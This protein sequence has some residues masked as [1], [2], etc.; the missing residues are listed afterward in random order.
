MVS[1]KR[2]LN[3]SDTDTPLRQVVS[4]LLEKI[5]SEAVVAD[6]NEVAAFR[7]DIRSLRDHVDQRSTPE[8]IV[9]TA[10]SAAVIMEAYNNEISAFLRKQRREL[11]NI[12][13][14]MMETVAA[15]TGEN[16][17]AVE[18]L[19]GIG[20]NLERTL[21]AADLDTLKLNLAECLQDFRQE[22]LRQKEE[23]E[24]M[25][26][27]LRRDIERGPQQSVPPEL[28]EIDE[29]TSLP[30]KDACVKAMHA[31][32]PPGKRRYVV[33]LVL[34]RLQAVNARFGFEVGNRVLCRFG[35]FIEQQILPEDR[36]FR[37]RGPALVA[38]LER[39]EGIDMIRAQIRRMLE[40]RLEQTLDVE[41][42]PVMI[43]VSARWSA[44]QL[45]TT[46]AAAEKQIETFAASQ[47]SREYI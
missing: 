6:E 20:D 8:E 42:R 23:A 21:A 46:V 47:M 7:T 44:F 45:T 35:E 43:T 15:I 12:V 19:R 13:T 22:T 38:V 30:L 28:T 37:W 32:I 1:I 18:R 10:E 11:K 36:L 16:T 25:I 3:R 9:S 24:N 17:R 29:A 39:P 27:A 26:I 31:S 14:I 34:N 40:S 41:G 2:Y 4:L 33:T 5:G